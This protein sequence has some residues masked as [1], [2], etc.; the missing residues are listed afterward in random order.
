[1][2]LHSP[3]RRELYTTSRPKDPSR[4]LLCTARELVSAS[5]HSLTN[6][7]HAHLSINHLAIQAPIWG[8]VYSTFA[9]T[10]PSS[11]GKARDLYHPNRLPTKPHVPYC[12]SL[13]PTKYFTGHVYAAPSLPELCHCY[14]VIRHDRRTC[15]QVS[16]VFGSTP[17]PSLPLKVS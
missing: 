15:A 9:L 11:I 17:S 1:V 2:L 10:K 14:Q 4:K 13:C 16:H 12:C 7:L 6:S 8:K 5:I 3:S